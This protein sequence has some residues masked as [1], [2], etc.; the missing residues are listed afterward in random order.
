M[1]GPTIQ[2]VGGATLIEL[3]NSLPGEIRKAQVAG[4]NKT[5]TQHRREN[6]VKPL[7][8]ATGIKR[9]RLNADIRIRRARTFFPIGRIQPARWGIPVPEYTWRM[10]PVDGT[11]T[12]ARIFVRFPN[13]L[14]WKLAAGFV[15]PRG[16][17]QHP[18]RSYN[19]RGP[20][21]G[22]LDPV[23]TAIGLSAAALAVEI[24]TPQKLQEASELLQRKVD[25]ELLR[26]FQR[27]I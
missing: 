13:A 27:R 7:M 1:A 25:I 23:E 9:K 26:Q 8:S 11:P 2:L 3:L 22:K 18:L 20:E 5:M 19:W 14:G 4:I 16:T 15:N 24:N 12:R 21:A 6:M 10:E 17:E